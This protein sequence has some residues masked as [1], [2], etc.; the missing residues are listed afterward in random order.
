MAWKDWWRSKP[1]VQPPA[2]EPEAKVQAEQ[3]IGLGNAAEDRG[4]LALAREHYEAALR[5]AP[6]MA[7]VH[8]NLGNLCLLEGQP[9][10]AIDAYQRA[11]DLQPE[12]AG[13]WFNLG[14]VHLRQRQ[15]GEAGK[16]Y[17][18]CL[19]LAPAHDEAELGLAL[20]LAETGDR[21]EAASAYRRLLA[22]R[23]GH[24]GGRANYAQFLTADKQYTAAAGQW[25][26]VL[27]HA[28]GH[29]YARGHACAA[30]AYACDWEGL[31][32][33]VAGLER[34]ALAGHPVALPFHLAILGHSASAQLQAA[35]T[36]AADKCPPQPPLP[37]RAADSGRIRLAYVSADFHRHATAALTARL[38][39]QHDRTRFEVSAWSF[40][41]DDGSPMRE[42]LERAFDHFHDVR[43]WSDEAIARAIHASGCDIAIDLK[44]STADARPAIFSARPAPIQVSW[45]GF[46]GTSGREV[47]DYLIAD[48]SLIGAGDLQ[49]YSERVVWLPDSYQ[50]NDDTREIA[51]SAPSRAELQLPEPGFVFCCFNNNFKITPRVF[52]LWMRLLRAVPGSVLWLLAD[53]REAQANLG[54]AAVAAGVAPERLVYAPRADLALHLARHCRADLFLDTLPCN[55]HTTASDAL[56]AGLPVLTCRG[57]TFAGRVAASLLLAAGLPELVTGTLAE[58]E[59]RALELAT[60]PT[61]LERLRER[62]G[63]ANRRLPLFDSARFCARLESAYA[64]MQRR[65]QAGSAPAHF[66]VLADRSIGELR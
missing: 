64:E 2:P 53:N 11:L 40:G 3:E 27:V 21:E 49:D 62:L 42:R 24:A 18:R 54:R 39:E 66:A 34:D 7:R 26:E 44:G 23:P 45:L 20:A 65:R 31:E 46:P 47:I 36:W 43:G 19:A 17:R 61:A 35:R 15:P 41:R 60:R 4:E 58:Y 16:A 59:E 48:A 29:P 6:S 22:R 5:L 10:A 38:F 56:W 12:H 28:P 55:A 9:A 25:R 63:H 13:A 57:D 1:A 51:A 52:H 32:A 14:N 30:R 50:A 33:E 8:L 37:A